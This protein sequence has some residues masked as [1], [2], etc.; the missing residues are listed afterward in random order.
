MA[1]ATAELQA[2]LNSMKI[3]LGTVFIGFVVATT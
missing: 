3:L 2:I 1:D